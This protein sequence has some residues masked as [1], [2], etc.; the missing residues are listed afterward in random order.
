LGGISFENPLSI[1]DESVERVEFKSFAIG[2]YFHL[3]DFR[4]GGGRVDLNMSVSTVIS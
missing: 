2:E 4:V 3:S 1:S